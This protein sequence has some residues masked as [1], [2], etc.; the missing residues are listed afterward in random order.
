[1]GQLVGYVARD[2]AGIVSTG[3]LHACGGVL[4]ERGLIV[5]GWRDAESEGFY[6]IR[7]WLTRHDADRIGFGPQAI[8]DQHLL[9]WPE[10]PRCRTDERRLSPSM[11]DLQ[12]ERWGSRVTVLGEEH[13]QRVIIGAMPAG[14]N[15]N[16]CPTLVELGI[17]ACN[18]HAKHPDPCVE[19][20]V[21]EQTVGYFTLAMTDRYRSLVESAERD[22]LTP[23]AL[24]TIR[25]GVKGGA[26][27]W[28]VQVEMQRV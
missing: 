5:G 20:R 8:P 16:H 11:T 1:M 7:V 14:W 15:R 4:E 21:M 2:Q 26:E 23:T 13:Y 18:P 27:I 9:P 3:M 10:I 25:R 24:A 22:R 6:G 17:A 28:R 19:V 12:A